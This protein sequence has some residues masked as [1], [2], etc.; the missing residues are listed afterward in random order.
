MS[1]QFSL[2]LTPR[3]GNT[4]ALI[5]SARLDCLEFSLFGVDWQKIVSDFLHL[6][7]SLFVQKQVGLRGY[8][9]RV[10]Y[11]HVQVLWSN[12]KD[13]PVK[14]LISGQ[15][16][17]EIGVDGIELVRHVLRHNDNAFSPVKTCISQIHL[18]LDDRS[19]GITAELIDDCILGGYLVTRLRSARK[20]SGYSLDDDVPI[21]T[22][23]TWYIGA[24]GADRL[25]RLYDKQ[26]ERIAAGQ[27]DPGPWFRF[28][29]QARRKCADVLARTLAREGL[30]GSCGILRGILDFREKDNDNESRRTP[31]TW[32]MDFCDGLEIIRTGVKKIPQT[33]NRVCKWLERS[34]SR[35]LSEVRSLLGND[36]LTQ[37]IRVG[38]NK[39]DGSDLLSM[40]LPLGVDPAYLGG[41][42]LFADYAIGSPF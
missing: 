38:E 14:T 20:I 29:V 33:L 4:G 9:K 32:W 18:A 8:P 25:V 5:S 27:D 39:I 31:L 2:P 30:S 24:F 7:P 23:S 17:D 36:W 10:Q 22:G 35:R 19:G 34:V 13:R 16:M 40:S 28:E 37:L 1:C 26:A 6:D 42:R 12:D 15:G 11:G 41:G 21:A 3:D